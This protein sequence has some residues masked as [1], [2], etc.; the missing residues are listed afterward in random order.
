MTPPA[1]VA[2]RWFCLRV[3]WEEWS[4]LRKIRGLVSAAVVFFALP[5]VSLDVEPRRHCEVFIVR[6]DTGETVTR[7]DHPYLGEANAQVHSL[8]GRLESQHVFD[9]CRGVDLDVALVSGAGLD[10]PA[11]GLVESVPI[12]RAR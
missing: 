8:L 6:R 4:S 10:I 11:S 9:F 7:F 2:G 3:E 12:K 1:D 5:V